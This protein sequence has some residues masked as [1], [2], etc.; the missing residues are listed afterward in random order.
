MAKVFYFWRMPSKAFL[1][2]TYVHIVGV[3]FVFCF[4]VFFN[5]KYKKKRKSCRKVRFMP[6]CPASNKYWNF[7]PSIFLNEVDR[8]DFFFPETMGLTRELHLTRPRHCGKPPSRNLK[9]DLDV[10]S[11]LGYRSLYANFLCARC[12]KGTTATH[13]ILVITRT[14]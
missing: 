5:I 10:T 3:F 6:L 13:S 12:Q 8:N 14:M 11:R 4:F 2:Y 7:F 9:R 1:I